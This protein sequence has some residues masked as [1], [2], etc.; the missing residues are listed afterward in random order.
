MEIQI[1]VS[2]VGKYATRE[3]GDT[4]EMIERPGGGLSL[5]LVDGQ[6]SGRGAK[7]VS[8]LVARKAISLLA[9]GVR[10]GAAARAAHDALFTQQGGQVQATLNIVSVDLVSKTLVLSR[11]NP[12]PVYVVR[13]AAVTELADPSRP[14]GLYRHTRPAISEIP[15]Q[16]DTVVVVYTDGLAT[17]GA[18][19]GKLIDL[20]AKVE[21]LHTA[22]LEAAQTWADR[23]LAEAL[24]YDDGRAADDISVL[25]VAVL[26]R[27]TPDEARHMLVRMPL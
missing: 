7:A 27:Q 6:H 10:D 26:K 1:A 15:L 21:K 12:N 13:P 23:L 14:I 9:E 22:G 24:A 18:R 3:S 8:N 16:A 4:L 2:K 5:V 20:R 11:N 25:V 19:K 17:A